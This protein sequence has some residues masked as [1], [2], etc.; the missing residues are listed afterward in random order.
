MKDKS[1]PV[2][3]SVGRTTEREYFIKNQNELVAEPL[4]VR[5]DG[6][7]ITLKAEMDYM[8]RDHLEQ[9][10]AFM[11]DAEDDKSK[12]IVANFCKGVP[13]NVYAEPCQVGAMPRPNGELSTSQEFRIYDV[14]GKSVTINGNG[15]GAGGKTGLYAVRSD[16][17]QIPVY[18]VKD[19][20]VTIKGKEYPIKL[21][22]GFYIFR[23][24]SVAECK[25][26]QTVPHWYV[27]PV[28][29]AQAYKMLGNGWTVKVISHLITCA[30]NTKPREASEF[31]ER[32][33]EGNIQFSLF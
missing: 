9:R 29:N 22:D 17:K 32:E 6:K 1:H 31:V 21:K 18:E 26:L 7:A 27:F 5:D 33:D 8:V 20:K 13:Y 3:G 15:G 11:N 19:G 16:G 2:I 10:W 23:K 24:L 14:N 30:L 12:C 28:S 25:R 4:N